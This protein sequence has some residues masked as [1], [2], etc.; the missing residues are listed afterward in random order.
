MQKP[1]KLSKKLAK[2]HKES[3]F[4]R[5][6]ISIFLEDYYKENDEIKFN[7]AFLN[8]EKAKICKED[9]YSPELVPAK[10]KRKE[11]TKEIEQIFKDVVPEYLY[12]DLDYICNS[13]FVACIR[14]YVVRAFESE[15]LI[16]PVDENRFVYN[17]LC[18][19]R[20]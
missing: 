20:K 9:D 13:Y 3:R 15:G 2:T 6:N 5:K 11:I 12:K 16:K 19:E 8:F 18:W 1:Q 17:M 10:L 4:W 7:F 14:Q